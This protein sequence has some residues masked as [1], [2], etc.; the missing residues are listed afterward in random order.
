MVLQ[1]RT[2]LTINERS[3]AISKPHLKR[4]QSSSSKSENKTT[5]WKSCSFAK[6][7]G[8]RYF[9]FSKSTK[10]S[11][12]VLSVTKYHIGTQKQFFE[13]KSSSF[14][15]WLRKDGFTPSNLTKNL[16]EKSQKMFINKNH[17][18]KQANLYCWRSKSIFCTCFCFANSH[19][20]N[21]FCIF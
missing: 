1:L 9:H 17:I 14:L 6:L 15:H 3:S 2:Q 11:I 20:K 7:L 12:Q 4:K 16:I 19:L 18:W 21:W 13:K 8:K 5:F 10:F